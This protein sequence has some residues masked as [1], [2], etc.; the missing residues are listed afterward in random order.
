MANDTALVRAG[1]ERAVIRSVIRHEQ[2]SIGLDV[3]INPGRANR[4]QVNRSPVKRVKDALGIVRAMFAPGGSESG[5]GDPAS[6][7]RFL[8]HLLV[9]LNPRYAGVLGD[10]EKTLKQRNSLL[11]SAA[12]ASTPVNVTPYAA[13]WTS[14]MSVWWSSART[15]WPD[16]L[17]S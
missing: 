1:S 8:D 17:T 2:R 5:E 12:K 15:S 6:R 7:R 10:Y 3:Q 11:R 4:L 13:P 14:G 9:Q 16:A